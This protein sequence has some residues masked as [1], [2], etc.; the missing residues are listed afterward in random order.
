MLVLNY[1]TKMKKIF[2]EKLRQLNE[3]RKKAGKKIL[4]KK[5][6]AREIFSSNQSSD[7]SKEQL[8][9]SI[10]SG[11]RRPFQ[12]NELRTIRKIFSCTIDELYPISEDLHIDLKSLK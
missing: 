5:D 7:K 2:E 3:A 6:L 10:L 11:N 12:A 8:L 1:P 9:S 4:Y